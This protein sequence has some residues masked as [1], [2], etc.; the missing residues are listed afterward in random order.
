MSGPWGYAPAMW[1]QINQTGLTPLGMIFKVSKNQQLTIVS[2][3]S[4]CGLRFAIGNIRKRKVNQMDRRYYLLIGIVALF[5]CI[6]SLVLG[7]DSRS[8]ARR[9]VEKQKQ[10]LTAVNDQL[11]DGASTKD[12]DR[13]ITAGY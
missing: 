1:R 6:G 13:V 2:G 12:T 8:I 3:L 11:N 10:E 9:S 4:S 5:F 7:M